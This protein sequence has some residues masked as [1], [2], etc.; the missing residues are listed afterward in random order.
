MLRGFS[1]SIFA[2]VFALFFVCGCQDY[3]FEMVEPS[4]VT[5]AT[6]NIVIEP[7]PADI[8]FVVDNSGSM[9]DEQDKL[10]ASFDRFIRVI[11]QE[12]DP[13]LYRIAIVT[14]DLD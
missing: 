8:V 11:A 9:A 14:T 6:R 10:A 13:D 4:R 3:L 5:E 2:L 1:L 12:Q 7:S